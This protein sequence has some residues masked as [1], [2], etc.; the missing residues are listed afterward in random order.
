MSG[1]PR[2]A[3]MAQAVRA[4]LAELIR[5]TVRDPRVEA[6]GLVSIDHVELNRD[7]SVAHVYVAFLGGDDAA[8]PAAVE[9]LSRAA[10]G[11]RGRL[12]RH[13]K[14]KRAPE[15]RF[16]HDTSVE[17]GLRLSEIVRNDQ[18]GGEGE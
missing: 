1:S 5:D 10:G 2:K 15:L 18:R 3:R 7:M 11:L 12:G 16:H 13:L 8:G 4:A 9:A 17:F 14:L 6:A